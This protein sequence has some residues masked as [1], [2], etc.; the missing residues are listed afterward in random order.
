MGVLHMYNIRVSKFLWAFAF[1]AL[2]GCSG[3]GQGEWE[4]T[5]PT[6]TKHTIAELDGGS[7]AVAFDVDRDGLEDIVAFPGGTEGDLMWFKN[8]TWEKFNITTQTERL[9]NMAPYDV[10]GDG[11][12][13]IATASEFA[14][15]DSNNGGLVQWIEAPDDPTTNQE[16]ALHYIDAVPTSHRMRWGD[17]DGDGRKELLVLPIIGVGVTG[18]EYIGA[19]TFRAYRIPGDP[20]GVWEQ[21][22]LDDS[23]LEVA[24]GISVVDWDGDPTADIL[25][26]S[27]DGVW[28]FQPGLESE[29]QHIGAGLDAPRPN[30]GSSE[31]GLGS[32]GVEGERFIATIEPWHGTDAVVYTP[33]DSDAELWSRE[34][35]GTEFEG[36]HALR[37]ADLNGDGYDEII[38]GARGGDWAL[39][40]YRYLPT[41]DSWEKIPLDIGGVAVSGLYISDITGDGA[42]D[43]LAIGGATDNVVLYENSP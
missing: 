36:G 13:D 30:R 22:V 16:W 15:N 5:F 7:Y 12:L 41:S 42:L 43:I 17:I 10:D 11:D 31:V 34:V 6:F 1:F 32:L 18:P 2:A 3:A 9:I 8:P 4:E 29:P 19:S 20:T 23:R 33:S 38:A 39:M 25:T 37:A 21:Q 35:I 26:A 14:L 28:L 24:H 40:I 27:L